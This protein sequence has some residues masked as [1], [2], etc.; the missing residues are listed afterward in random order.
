MYEDEVLK[1]VWRIKDAIAARHG[2]DVRAIAKALRE[3]QGKDGRRVVTLEPK[4]P[5]VR[6]S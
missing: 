2:Y 6:S 5:V 4:R 3:K 1:E